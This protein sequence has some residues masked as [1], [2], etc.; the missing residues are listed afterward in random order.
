MQA[1]ESEFPALRKGEHEHQTC[2][3]R[4]KKADHPRHG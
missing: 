2:A 3:E 4:M 1:I